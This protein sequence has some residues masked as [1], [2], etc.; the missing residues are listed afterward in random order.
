MAEA[1]DQS[2]WNRL[3]ALQATIYNMFRGKRDKAIDP[4]QFYPW[5]KQVTR[6]HGEPMT[7]EMSESLKKMFDAAKRQRQKKPG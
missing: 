6:T 1:V 3:F 7:K 5:A 2:R 4:L